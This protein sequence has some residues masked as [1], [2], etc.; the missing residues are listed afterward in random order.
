V[1][2]T[3]PPSSLA[4]DPGLKGA[5][6]FNVALLTTFPHLVGPT[7]PQLGKLL[8]K[9]PQMG[10]EVSPC[11]TPTGNSTV[12]IGPR[13]I[14]VSG[15]AVATTCMPAASATTVIMGPVTAE[16][17]SDP[18]L[19]I[20]LLLPDLIEEELRKYNILS[21]W[22]HIIEGLHQGFDVGLSS[23]PLSTYIFRKSFLFNHRLILY[24]NLHHRQASCRTLFP[25][26][27]GHRARKFNWSLS[28]I[29]PGTGS[30][31]KFHK[32]SNDTGHVISEK[33]P[34]HSICECRHQ[35]G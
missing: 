6:A 17:R 19:V 31:T 24:Q 5:S 32:T 18:R 14:P 27:L 11:S 23:P 21:D 35:L 25:C 22:A 7:K 4:R 8:L 15:T 12:S 16:L 20:T 29:P 28:D 34:Q 33:Q 2:V 10:E 1:T 30:Q 13:P 3:L 26:F 9:C